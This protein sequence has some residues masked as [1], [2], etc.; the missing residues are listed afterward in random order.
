M[1]E[2]AR[3]NDIQRLLDDARQTPLFTVNKIRDGFEVIFEEDVK[4]ISEALDGL[5]FLLQ[6]V[7]Q[8]EKELEY[9]RGGRL[10]IGN[11]LF[12]KPETE[13]NRL[14]RE[15]LQYEMIKMMQE[16]SNVNQPH[17]LAQEG[18]ESQ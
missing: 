15:I 1:D 17:A 3:I 6:L 8:Q 10:K 4:R 5:G 18:G 7:E 14:N 12:G 16:E 13:E 2:Q 11:S 9:W